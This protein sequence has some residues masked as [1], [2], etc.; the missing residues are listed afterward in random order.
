MS[1]DLVTPT[2][3]PVEPRDQRSG[4]V[5]A[6]LWPVASFGVLLIGWQFLVRLFGVPEYILPVPT[7]FFAKLLADRALIW[8]IGRAHV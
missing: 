1:E 3:P 7:E 5:S 4:I 6:I 2:A 8:Q